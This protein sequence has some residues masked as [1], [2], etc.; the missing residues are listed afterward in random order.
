MVGKL[1]GGLINRVDQQLAQ[2]GLMTVITFRIIPFAPFSLINLIAGV[3][4]ISLRDFALGT[5]IGILPGITALAFVADRLSESLRRPDLTT[6]TSLF[7]AVVVMAGGLILFRKWIRQR[8]LRK[9]RQSG[10]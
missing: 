3:S 5:L 8:Y 7:A 4:T 1:S 9:K 2:N 10:S 6:F